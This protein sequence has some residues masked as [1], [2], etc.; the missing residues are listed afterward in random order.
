MMGSTD[1][2]VRLGITSRRRLHRAY[3]CVSELCCLHLTEARG[4]QDHS[5]GHS[6]PHHNI[7]TWLPRLTVAILNKASHASKIKWSVWCAEQRVDQEGSRPSSA[8]MR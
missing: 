8:R 1:L 3:R 7:Q 5:R 6:S 2:P 4:R